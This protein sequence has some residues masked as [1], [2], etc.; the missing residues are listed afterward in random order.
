MS[1]AWVESG[2][3]RLILVRIRIRASDLGQADNYGTEKQK[4]K[5]VFRFCVET[6]T[7]LWLLLFSVPQPARRRKKRAFRTQRLT[8]TTSPRLRGHGSSPNLEGLCSTERRAPA[9]KYEGLR[10]S[11][12][13]G[14]AWDVGARPSSVINFLRYTS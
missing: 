5:Q 4:I 12:S 11:V 9:A 8:A 1:R 7:R 14:L 13:R 10:W 3:V 2:R 6:H